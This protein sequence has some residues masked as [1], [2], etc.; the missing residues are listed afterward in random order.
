MNDFKNSSFFISNSKFILKINHV[1]KFL[2][3]KNRFL[4]TIHTNKSKQ[5]II[6]KQSPQSFHVISSAPLTLNETYDMVQYLLV[7]LNNRL[8]G[9]Q[10]Q[11]L[12]WRLTQIKQL[13][14]VLI[15]KLLK[16]GRLIS[17]FAKILSIGDT[18]QFG[19]HKANYV[20][21]G[22]TRVTLLAPIDIKPWLGW[23]IRHPWVCITLKRIPFI[24][25]TNKTGNGV[26]H[27]KK[28][29]SSTKNLTK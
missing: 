1:I 8:L 15:H 12:T 20:R 14:K 27:T 13:T 5:K 25:F 3:N 11:A 28:V 18:G 23:S 26:R 9:I 4:L 24:S 2:H 21:L 22:Q 29:N 19:V 6:S 16:L 10:N 7:Q 17:L